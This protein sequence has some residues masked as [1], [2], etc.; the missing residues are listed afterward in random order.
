M[1]LAQVYAQ[2]KR[3]MSVAQEEPNTAVAQESKRGSSY[4]S[5]DS[6]QEA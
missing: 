4:F 3:Q 6:E 2:R 5:G 1:I